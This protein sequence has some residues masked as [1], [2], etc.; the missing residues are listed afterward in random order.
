MSLNSAE[1]GGQAN[2]GLSQQALQEPSYGS[3]VYVTEQEQV[4]AEQEMDKRVAMQ[5]AVEATEKVTSEKKER[6][7]SALHYALEAKRVIFLR[8]CSFMYRQLI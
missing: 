7:W 1:L 4:M 2:Q 5:A 6:A 8:G 3:N